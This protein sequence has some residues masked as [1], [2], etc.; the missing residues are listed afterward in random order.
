MERLRPSSGWRTPLRGEQRRACAACRAATTIAVGVRPRR[1]SAI[2][3]AAVDRG[4]HLACRLC[5][6]RAGAA[7]AQ[8]HVGLAGVLLGAGRAAER[9]DARAL[10]AAR[11]AVQEAAGPA[12][13]LG[14]ALGDE[15]VAP[16]DVRGDAGD[17]DLALDPRVV[18]V[19]EVEAELACASGRGRGSGARKQVPVL[20]SVVPPTVRPSGSTI[21]GRAERRGLA[22]RRGTAGGIMSRGRPVM[23]GG[24]DARRPPRGRRRRR[25]PRRARGR[26]ARRRRRCRSRRRPRAR[27]AWPTAVGDAAGRRSS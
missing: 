25:R 19:V 5:S 22:R 2:D 14:A 8:R 1:P 11:V 21:G 3:G 27:G 26:R 13:R 4:A 15:R 17:A 16:G 24:G 6:A 20:T 12:E 18:A 9:A 10:A 7:R 23:L